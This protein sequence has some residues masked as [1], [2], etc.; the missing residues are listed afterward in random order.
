MAVIRTLDMVTC[1]HTDGLAWEEA[2]P[3]D[4]RETL[5]E[6]LR[7]PDGCTFLVIVPGSSWGVPGVR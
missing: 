6:A 4:R 7:M 5:F 3:G 2:A 1:I